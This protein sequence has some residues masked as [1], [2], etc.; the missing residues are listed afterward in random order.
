MMNK[1]KK[2]LQNDTSL[3]EDLMDKGL[4]T[5]VK[6]EG[7]NQIKILILEEHVDNVMFGYISKY[8]YYENWIRCAI[9]DKENK[10]EQFFIAP[11]MQV[12]NVFSIGC[13]IKNGK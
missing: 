11:T 10:N 6:E 2:F 5:F 7:P 13:F 9:E 4:E 8:D 3:L 12:S 1:E